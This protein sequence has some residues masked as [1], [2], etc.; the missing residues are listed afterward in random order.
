MLDP[1]GKP[2]SSCQWLCVA[3]GSPWF[4][5]DDRRSPVGILRGAFCSPFDSSRTATS[6]QSVATASRSTKHAHAPTTRPH[7]HTARWLTGVRISK[8]RTGSPSGT[9]AQGE[10]TETAVLLRTPPAALPDGPRLL[11]NDEASLVRPKRQQT[12]PRGQSSPND[13]YQKEHHRA[14]HH[15]AMPNP[16]YHEPNQRK[17]HAT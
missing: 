17:E 5:G 7:C 15:A 9:T 1:K 11:R 13:N 16:D 14:Y 12:V 8:T 6:R 4:S 2:L 3:S 10:T